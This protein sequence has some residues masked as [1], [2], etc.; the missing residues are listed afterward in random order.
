MTRYRKYAKWVGYCFCDS[1]RGC[2][3]ILEGIGN[4]EDGANCYY[5]AQ[6]NKDGTYTY[7]CCDYAKF[8]QIWN[9]TDLPR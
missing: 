1:V 7:Y 6:E 8:K 5:M 9:D 2:G 4:F 3:V